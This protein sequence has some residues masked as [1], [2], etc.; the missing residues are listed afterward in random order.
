MAELCEWKINGENT[1][2]SDHFPNGKLMGRTRLKVT[3]SQ[4]FV[5]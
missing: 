5:K 3:I 1:V 2:E 4:L